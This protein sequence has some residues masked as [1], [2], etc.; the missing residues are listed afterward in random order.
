M[1]HLITELTKFTMTSVLA[2][3]LASCGGAEDRKEKYLEKGKIFLEEK[4][5]KKARVE[6]KNV[7]QIDPKYAEA[8]FYMGKLEE[9]NREPIKAVSNYKKAL[10]LY[11]KHTESKIKLAKIFVIVGTDEY[12]AEAK[13]LLAE[14][15]A[16]LPKNIEA[17]LISA[18]I[19]Y[20]V[21]SKSKA[22]KE[23]ETLVANHPNL[24]DGISLL[25]TIYI[26][27]G[28]DSKAIE[29]LHNGVVN[30]PESISLLISLSKLLVKNK[31]YLEAEK[32][33]KQVISI[34]PEKY[35]YQM[36]LSS[37]YVVSKQLD[38]AELVLRESIRQDDEN[39]QRYLM[40]FEMLA[41]KVSLKKADEEI[42]Q[43]VLSKPDLYALKFA[44]VKFNIKLGKREEAKSIL[45]QIIADKEYDVE[46]VTARNILAKYILEE[47]NESN[48]KVY[49]DEVLAE[50]PNNNDALLLNSKIS[51]SNLDAVSAIND[52]RTIVKNNPK[53][54]EA[55]LL[56]AKAY[57]LNGE[58]NLAE[59]ELKKAIESSPIDDK[60]HVNYANYL[61]SKGRIEESTAVIDKAL[62]YFK[63]SYDLMNVKLQILASQ[64][65]SAEALI[66]LNMME[67]TAPS[68]AD[69]NFMKG[70]FYIS[71][72]KIPMA[73]EELEKAYAKS[74]DKFKPL[75]LIVKSYL[76]INE[77]EKALTRL[78]LLINENKE[79]AVAILL[80]GH[81]YLVQNKIE[82]A[83][84]QFK[85][86]SK[87]AESWLPPYT[88]LATTF[89]AEKNIDAA[90]SV[91]KNAITKLT[92]KLPA[93]LQL[94]SIYERSKD[95]TNAMK[96]Y[97]EILSVHSGNKLAINNYASLLLD[98][99]VESDVTI[100]LELVKDFEKL[101]QS[102]FQDTLGWAYAKSGNN[103]KAIELLKPVVD[104]LPK[105]AVFRYHLG[106]ALYA[107]G[108]KAA[109]KS[110]LE[111]A[112]SSE[113][114]FLGKDKAAEL[115]QSI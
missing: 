60:T 44:Q 80:T 62:T 22:T 96:T 20:K 23:L 25:S 19:E 64:G 42:K 69:V 51:L 106:Y 27:K 13:K 30:N 5:Y 83:K 56:L 78:Q 54:T 37:F 72:Q 93:Q 88:S 48:A 68:N 14:I 11:P 29:L 12:I 67:Q 90:V 70:K 111:I 28:E 101:K 112:V 76:S 99:G 104:K 59:N 17:N 84:N 108:D 32:Y 52:L 75:E 63:D 81:V 49:V 16:E 50:Y 46:G 10:D 89:L 94:A 71:K 8:Y 113:Q 15:N 61:A 31:N 86:A 2:V 103:L 58:V 6:F 21:G 107:M 9:E 43:A 95:F 82:D 85:L 110:H 53:N 4:N 7:L 35:S 18:T 47:G 91:Y 79:D 34:E 65:K 26:V 115:L 87:Y 100:A 33:L 73:I 24:V 109:A 77:A 45:K 74:S 98:Y 57:E 1:K 114:M 55:S 3:S 40:L 102:A 38:K 39:A 105:T 66:L 36:L 92:N 97:K 41:T